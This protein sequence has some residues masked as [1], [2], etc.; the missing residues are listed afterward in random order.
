MSA[1]ASERAARWRAARHVLL[2]RLD[3]LGDLLMTTP[4]LAAV[5]AALPQARLALL[6]SPPGAA[7]APHLAGLDATIAFDAP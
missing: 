6:A 3:N 5:R 1:A 7:L 4:A 2:V